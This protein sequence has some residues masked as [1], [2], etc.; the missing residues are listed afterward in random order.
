MA[1]EKLEKHL[2][3]EHN[4]I[5]VENE[6]QAIANVCKSITSDSINRIYADLF[7]ISRKMSGGEPVSTNDIWAVMEKIRDLDN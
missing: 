4:L 2:F 7:Q 5:L 3:D 1:F 6:L